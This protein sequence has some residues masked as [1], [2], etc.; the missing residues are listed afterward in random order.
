MLTIAI[1]GAWHC[2]GL[3]TNEEQGKEVGEPGLGFV[4]HRGCMGEGR[5]SFRA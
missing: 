5:A 4:P 2:N 3:L 1:Y